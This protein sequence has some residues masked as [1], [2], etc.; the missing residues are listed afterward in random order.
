MALDKLV[1]ST[2][3]DSDL[4]DVAD[5]I[6]AKSGGSTPLAF[7]AGFLTEIAAIQT[8]TTP[9][10]TKQI[11]ITA[12]GT[13]TEDVTNYASAEITVNVPSSGASLPSIITKI[14]GG[15]FTP[16]SDEATSGYAI[17]HSLGVVPTGVA[18]MAMNIVAE[19]Y[20]NRSVNL[21]LMNANYYIL[22]QINTNGT[23]RFAGGA[24]PS[25]SFS[26]ND[27]M[28]VVTSNVFKAGTTYQWLAWV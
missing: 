12:N 17:S 22:Y 24:L 8:G 19:S 20:A 23:G 7:P 21:A 2:L 15:S 18:I 11:S 28:I 27:F 14:D 25:G 1:D 26:A 5:A 16:V 13:T 9:T 4:G 6:R 3:L 10:G